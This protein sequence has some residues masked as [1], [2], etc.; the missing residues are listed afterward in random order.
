MTTQHNRIMIYSTKTDGIDQDGR[1][2][3]SKRYRSG[4]S[5]DWLKMKNS[6][7]PCGAR[8]PLRSLGT[9]RKPGEL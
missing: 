3:R 9:M 8:A 2:A 5:P 6:D 1:P 4:R 7:A